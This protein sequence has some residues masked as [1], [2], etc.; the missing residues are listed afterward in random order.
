MDIAKSLNFLSHNKSYTAIN[1][2]GLTVALMFVVLIGAYVWQERSI[3][4]QHA[5]ADRILV[6]AIDFGD[7]KGSIL[8]SHHILQKQ[9][10]AMYPGVESS[11]GVAMMTMRISKGDEYVSTTA[12]VADSTFFNLFDYPLLEGDRA[13]CLATASDAVI[14]RGLARKLFGDEPAVGKTITYADGVKLKVTGVM[15]DL[16]M[17]KAGTAPDTTPINSHTPTMAA[18]TCGWAS[19][20]MFM[21]VPMMPPKVG[22]KAKASATAKANDTRQSRRLSPIM[23]SATAQRLAPKSRRAAISR[24]RRPE[25]ATVRLT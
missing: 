23:R 3:D 14:T 6:S 11:C 17:S 20:A 13:T 4:H 25:R 12:L 24:E 16:D 1:I 15:A 2:F 7:G 18:T 5:K 21:R 10:R 22:A 19:K 8:G 9:L